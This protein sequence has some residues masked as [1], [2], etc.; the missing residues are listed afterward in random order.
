[1]S[2]SFWLSS[3]IFCAWALEPGVLAMLELRT[4]HL[5]GL[6][7]MMTNY[8]CAKSLSESPLICVLTMLTML[9]ML[10]TV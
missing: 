1:M 9:T 10:S 6:P 7:M 8:R 5:D 4:R 3:M 2:M